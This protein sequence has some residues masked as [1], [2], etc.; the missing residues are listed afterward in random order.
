MARH[1]ST[2]T[3][4]CAGMEIPPINPLPLSA[5]GCSS[6]RTIGKAGRRYLTESCTGWIAAAELRYSGKVAEAPKQAGSSRHDARG[7]PYWQAPHTSA[8]GAATSF[9]KSLKKRTVDTQAG[10]KRLDTNASACGCTGS[11]RA[12][13]ALDD[14]A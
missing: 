8:A 14:R 3:S 7:P 10:N 11:C 1:G 5:R 4:L 9:T 6:L 12:R 2:S 13:R